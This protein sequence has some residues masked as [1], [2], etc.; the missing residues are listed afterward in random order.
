MCMYLVGCAVGYTDNCDNGGFSKS[1]GL[2][3][4]I[5]CGRLDKNSLCCTLGNILLRV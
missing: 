1:E 5:H 3:P 4:Y 2:Y